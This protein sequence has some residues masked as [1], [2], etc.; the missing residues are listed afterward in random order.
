MVRARV[1]P[2]VERSPAGSQQSIP[3]LGQA[4]S[5]AASPATVSPWEA[6]SW[7]LPVRSRGVDK[8]HLSPVTFS[9]VLAGICLKSPF[10]L[11]HRRSVFQNILGTQLPL[12]GC[13]R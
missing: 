4:R 8:G 1:W 6:P 11:H 7:L 13:Q 5:L 3:P 9:D 10:Y 12:C 2:G